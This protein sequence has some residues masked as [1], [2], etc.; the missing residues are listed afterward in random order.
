MGDI[1]EIPWVE[2]YRPKSLTDVVSQ[3]LSI[4]SLTKFVQ[5]KTLPHMIFTGPAGT[6]KT[7]TAYA[8]I[9]DF[10]GGGRISQDSLLERNA[11]DEARMEDLEDIK[12]FVNHTGINESTG[13]KFVILD[14]ADNI[15]KDVQSALRRVIE[16]A[17]PSVR[18]I[19]LC[20]YIENIIDPILSRCAVFRFYPLPKPY[21][22][23]QLHFIANKELGENEANNDQKS[24]DRIATVIDAIYF[25]TQGDMR[26]AINLFQ[27]VVALLQDEEGIIRLDRLK[28]DDVYEL[29]GY[30]PLERFNKV[31]QG[32]T[33]KSFV[34]TIR[35]FKGLRGVSSRG[36]IRQ[37]LDAILKMK[38]EYPIRDHAISVLAEYDYRLTLE[39]D[40]QIQL[41]GLFAELMQVLP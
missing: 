22:S 7:S 25:I 33:Q 20:N 3:T 31:F 30:V 8:L 17:P 21:F 4:E 26:Q 27:M 14:E 35:A 29:S 38:L 6:G 2:K 34:K 24:N 11:S 23:Q 13:F 19:F 12:N 40:P 28:A 36:V 37:L 5:Q 39:A 10:V 15:N 41:D 9:N 16:M 32:V 1:R 18:F